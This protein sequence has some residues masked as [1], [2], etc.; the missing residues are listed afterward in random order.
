M[1]RL[2][3]LIFAL[4]TLLSPVGAAAMMSFDADNIMSETS[5]HTMSVTMSE[6]CPS[7]SSHD[8]C[9]MDSMSSDLCKAKCA[10]SC[11]VSPAHIANFSFNF[12]FVISNSN[13][14]IAF[15]HFNSRSISPELRP[16]LV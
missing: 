5:E 3:I 15:L 13:L 6:H 16:P 12:P 14:E 11:T 8:A 10:A 1:T 4:N 9:N 2:L 7:M